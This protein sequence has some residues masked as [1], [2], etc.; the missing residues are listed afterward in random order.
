MNID[1]YRIFCHTIG[2]ETMNS[3]GLMY[4]N[5]DL[6]LITMNFIE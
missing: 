5:N 1:I 2:K 3:P 4:E 6:L